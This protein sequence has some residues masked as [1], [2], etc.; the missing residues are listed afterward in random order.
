MDRT[1]A[2]LPDVA[3]VLGQWWLVSPSP[4]CPCLLLFLL[5]DPALSPL[6]SNQVASAALGA[7]WGS[8]RRQQVGNGAPHLPPTEG[9]Q[10]LVLV[11]ALQSVGARQL[12]KRCSGLLTVAGAVL[13]PVS[14]LRSVSAAW[15]ET[16]YKNLTWGRMPTKEKFGAD[17]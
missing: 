5:P 14:R 4:L 8:G 2:A 11:S 13:F 16:S 3:D 9:F 17:G 6:Y 15:A 12:L 7:G 10:W 1:F